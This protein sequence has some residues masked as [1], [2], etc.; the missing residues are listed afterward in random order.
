MAV[1]LTPVQEPITK[2]FRKPWQRVFDQEVT[3]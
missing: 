2:P 1:S 3:P